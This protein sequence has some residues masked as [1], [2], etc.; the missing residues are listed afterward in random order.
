M[1]GHLIFARLHAD[2]A[3]CVLG[4]IEEDHILIATDFLSTVKQK[5]GGIDIAAESGTLL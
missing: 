4:L 2:T 1:K 3:I 5:S